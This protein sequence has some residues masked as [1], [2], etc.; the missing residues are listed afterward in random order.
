LQLPLWEDKHE[1]INMNAGDQ[2]ADEQMRLWNGPS[3]RTWVEA[4]GLLDRMFKPF[5]DLLAAAVS[6]RSASRVLDVGCG[7]GSTTLAASRVVG[8]K[9][10]CVGIDISEPMIAVARAHAEWQG[11]PASFIR[12]DAQSHAF[13]PGTFDMIISRFGVMFFED[14]VQAFANL[15]RAASRGGELCFIAWRSPAENPFMTTAERAAAHLIPNLPARRPDGPGQFAFADPQRI[16]GILEKSGWGDIA[17]Q[18]I[19]VTCTLFETELDY[20]VTRFGPVGL[21][22]QNADEEARMRITATVRAAFASYVHGDEARFTAACWN[23]R[24]RP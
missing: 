5:E 15:R 12:A 3:G 21:A 6:A 7:T 9:G 18:P 13:E 17:I 16:Q 1:E 24:A 22:L 23:V 2:T 14:F 4:Q 10:L 19:D 8:A 11:A 20:Y